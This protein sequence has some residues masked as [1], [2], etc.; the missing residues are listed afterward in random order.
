MCDTCV[1]TVATEMNRA[2]AIAGFDSPLATSRATSSSRSDSSKASS[3]VTA[4]AGTVAGTVPS[5]AAA[6]T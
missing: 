3:A 4:G 5:C 6:A 1:L 2:E